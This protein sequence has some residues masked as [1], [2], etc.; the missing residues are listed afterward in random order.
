MI[1]RHCS[2]RSR[3]SRLRIMVLMA[4]DLPEPVVPAIKRCGIRARSTITDSP[5]IVLPSQS[6]SLAQLAQIDLLSGGVGQFDADH[7][8]AGHHGDTRRKRAHG[9]RDVVGQS[10]HPRRLD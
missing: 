6:A 3:Y 8:A 4:T 2:G 9:A 7:I 5:P 10:D 1:S